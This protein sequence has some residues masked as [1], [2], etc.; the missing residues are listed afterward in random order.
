MDTRA[1]GDPWT[2]AQCHAENPPAAKTCRDCGLRR[3]AMPPP[4]PRTLSPRGRILLLLAIG[5]CGFLILV[6]V[7]AGMRLYPLWQERQTREK[8][9]RVQRTY[10]LSLLRLKHIGRMLNPCPAL[11]KKATARPP[12]PC[13][14]SAI[15]LTTPPTAQQPRACYGGSNS[16]GK[17]EGWEMCGNGI[18]SGE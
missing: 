11:R 3:Q 8:V 14:G 15:M 17:E 7:N 16:D 9:R 10:E 4:F 6:T 2:C 1:Q 18:S 5:F 13:R 12:P